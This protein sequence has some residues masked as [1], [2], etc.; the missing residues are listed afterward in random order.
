MEFSSAALHLART[1]AL[2]IFKCITISGTCIH[3]EVSVYIKYREQQT[4]G[5]KGTESMYF[6]PEQP[7]TCYFEKNFTFVPFKFIS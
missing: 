5:T 7:F 3:T 4:L 6:F 2:E 1:R